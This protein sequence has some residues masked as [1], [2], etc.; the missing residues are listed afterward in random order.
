MILSIGLI[1]KNEE[2]Y[3]KQCLKGIKPLLDNLDSELIIT[4]TGSNDRTVDIAK[5]FTDKIY[6]FEWCNDFSKARNANIEKASGKWYMYLDADEILINSEA[7]IDFFKSG[8]S[9]KYTGMSVIIR[10]FYD[11]ECET[12]ADYSPLRVFRNKKENRFKNA[13]HEILENIDLS[14]MYNSK[15]VFNHYGYINDRAGRYRKK[16]LKYTKMTADLV[17]ENPEN[18]RS[19]MQ[20]VISYLSLG[21]NKNA[22]R[23]VCEAM[24][25]CRRLGINNCMDFYSAFYYYMLLIKYKQNDYAALLHI[26]ENYFNEIKECVSTLNVYALLINTYSAVMDFKKSVYYF[27]KYDK[28]YKRAENGFHTGDELCV[29]KILK[30]PADYAGCACSAVNACFKGGE[31]SKGKIILHSIIKQRY[32]GGA[33]FTRMLDMLVYIMN[34]ES[35][36]KYFSEIYKYI[37]SDQK[38]ISKFNSYFLKQNMLFCVNIKAYENIYRFLCSDTENIYYDV[39]CIRNGV[40]FGSGNITEKLDKVRNIFMPDMLYIV[41]KN[42]ISSE[43]IPE[44]IDI[45]KKM[46]EYALN[47]FYDAEDVIYNYIINSDTCNLSDLGLMY[48]FSGKSGLYDIKDIYRKKAKKYMNIY[49]RDAECFIP[50]VRAGIYDTGR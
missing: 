12:Y 19:R 20:L 39:Y 44:E 25:V 23:T 37:K 1:V 21:D 38:K 13:V 40:Y 16:K 4:D 33:V 36:E 31:Y 28:L 11:E 24:D 17:K 47:N 29:E 45:I 7:V 15:A 34:K 22:E 50:Q 26:S 5:E 32:S 43:F 27:E 18:I 6:Y 49:N 8:K 48:V 42:N 10:S 3:L 30:E 46:M 9:E 2:K 35:D 41:C 14:N